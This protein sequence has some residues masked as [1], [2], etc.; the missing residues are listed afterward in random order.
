VGA[1]ARTIRVALVL[2]FLAGGGRSQEL[3]SLPP[4]QGP[5]VPTVTFTKSL[6]G[7]N[8][9]YYSITV[10]SMGTTSY[11]A[12]PNSERRTGEPEMD[13]F[14]ATSRTRNQIFQLTEKL[15]F[16]KG[17][18]RTSDENGRMGWKSLTFAQG[19]IQNEIDYT[20]SKN[21]SIKRLTLLFERIATTMEYGWELSRL[22]AD[23]PTGVAAELKQMQTQVTRR[24]LAEFEA[25]APIVREIAFDP[26]IPEAS[27]RYAVE[28]LKE[29]HS[30][31]KER[32]SSAALH[33]GGQEFL[34]YE[35]TGRRRE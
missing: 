12:E 14:T 19:P 3:P 18:L 28:L 22:R 2:F 35:A 15:H 17:K 34:P 33:L 31:T 8:P 26:R 20:S 29:T 11:W 9:S 6:W 13:D 7:A 10:S 1:V 27:R 4:L 5:A 25:I 24:R 30:Q 21:R 32:A 23:D 16:F